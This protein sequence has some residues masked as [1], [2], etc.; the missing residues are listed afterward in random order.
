M[1]KIIQSILVFAVTALVVSSCGKGT[2]TTKPLRKDLTQAVYASGRL[3][4][5]NDYKVF[6]KYAGYVKTIHVKVGDTVAAGQPLITIRNEQTEFNA[7]SA[8]NAMQL[9]VKNASPNSPLLQALK[10]EMSSSHSRYELDSV[11]YARY[12][13]LLKQNAAT[14]LQA[15]QSKMQFDV[16]K[17]TWLKNQNNYTATKD[18]LN[19]EATNAELQ[20]KTLLANRNEYVVLSDIKGMV[21]DIDAKV[22]E[23]VIQNK[24]VMEIGDAGSF[25]VELNVDETDI[26]LVAPGQ[27]VVFTIEAYGEEVF[28]GKVQQIYPRIS[29]SNKTARVMASINAPAAGKF[30]SSLSVEANI[31]VSIKKNILVVPREYLFEGDKVKIKGKEEPVRIKKGISDLEFVEVLEGCTENDELVLP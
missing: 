15:D 22:G 14:Q 5:L 18:R 10:N 3:Y 17:Q 26:S 25:E 19:T 11:N 7:E 31:I 23:M 29:M 6:S 27:E 20:Y 9:A 13:T 4:P 1:K 24:P 28:K 12:S 8:K 2:K 21:Y 30:Y 16:S